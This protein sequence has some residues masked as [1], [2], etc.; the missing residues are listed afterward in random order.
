MLEKLFTEGGVH[1]GAHLGFFSGIGIITPVLGK[2]WELN[3][4][5]WIYS[6]G[7]F[8]FGV[9]LILISIVMIAFARKSFTK[10]T[11]SVGWMLIIPGILAILF[12]AFGEPKVMGGIHDSISGFAILKPALR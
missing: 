1:T 3:I 9:V 5:P 2:A 8:T 12:A 6:P 4:K 11:K 7:I 10:V